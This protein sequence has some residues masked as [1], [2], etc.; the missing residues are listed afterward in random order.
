MSIE[1]T[2]VYVYIKSLVSFA[3]SCS[4]Y[5]SPLD[6]LARVPFFRVIQIIESMREEKK[7]HVPTVYS[8]RDGLSRRASFV[9]RAFP[10]LSSIIPDSCSRA[11]FWFPIAR[12]GRY[13]RFW[14][15]LW[16]RSLHHPPCSFFISATN[17]LKMY[18]K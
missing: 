12:I 5:Q 10:T 17:C 8:N 18:N 15:T 2:R 3:P 16:Q 11:E 14:D 13:H 1:Q 9:S 7:M 4:K 6:E